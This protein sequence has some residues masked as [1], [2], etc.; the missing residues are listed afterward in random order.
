METLQYAQPA[1]LSALDMDRLRD[2]KHNFQVDIGNKNRIWH[3]SGGM[4]DRSENTGVAKQI[5]I[6]GAP[7]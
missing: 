6:P 1:G 7:I 3:E 2:L 5:Y 4:F